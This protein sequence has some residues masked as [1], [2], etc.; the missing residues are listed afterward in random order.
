METSSFCATESGIISGKDHISRR[1]PNLHANSNQKV[2]SGQQPILIRDRLCDLHSF[3]NE[4]RRLLNLPNL[5]FP[6]AIRYS[7]HDQI[8]ESPSQ[9]HSGSIGKIWEHELWLVLAIAHSEWI[10]FNCLAES[11]MMT[12]N[13]EGFVVAA[14]FRLLCGSYRS[15]LQKIA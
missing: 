12:S 9:I 8:N 3:W 6:F 1:D 7:C 10:K 11:G 14:R 5:S 2:V 13:L 4:R 15:I